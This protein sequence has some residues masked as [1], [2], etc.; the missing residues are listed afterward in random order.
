MANSPSER[1]RLSRQDWIE[2]GLEAVGEAGLAALAVEPLAERLGITKGS[3]YWHFQD[4]P[5]F[6]EAVLQHWAIEMP[7]LAIDRL[8]RVSNPRDRLLQLMTP[9]ADV[10]LVGRV[11]IALAAAV[12]D[13]RVRRWRQIHDRLWIDFATRAYLE[14][15]HADDEARFLARLAYSAYLGLTSLLLVDPE[16]GA[17]ASEVGA[18][19]EFLRRILVAPAPPDRVA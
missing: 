9:P 16:L 15:G 11:D 13:D 12:T 5:T 3:F 6:V 17:D 10:P 19:A 8:Q 1:R 2:A 18:Y 7:T 4:L 14:L